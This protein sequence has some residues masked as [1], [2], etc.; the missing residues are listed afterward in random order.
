[1]TE[2]NA[3]PLLVHAA[4]R[5]LLD[6]VNALLRS[7]GISIHSTWIPSLEDMPDALEQLNPEMLLTVDPSLDALADLATLRDQVAPSVPLVVLRELCTQ[8]SITADMLRGARDSVS[9]QFPDR[10]VAVIRRELRA[11][12][13]ERT[14]TNTLNVAQEYRRRLQV[15]VRSSRDAIAQVQEGIIVDVNEAW[16]EMLGHD[17]TEVLTGQ[18]VMDNFDAE[19]QEA[20]RGALAACARGRWNELPL[21]VGAILKNGQ[22]VALNLILSRSEHDGEPSVQLMS[23]ARRRDERQMAKELEAAVHQDPATGLW[24]RRRLLQLFSEQVQRPV[25]GGGR[26]LLCLRI[27]RVADIEREIGIMHTDELLAQFAGL[28]R[29]HAGPNDI[30][31]HL[32]GVTLAALVERGNMRDLEAWCTALIDKV[33]RHPFSAGGNAVQ[34]TCSIGLE[35]VQNGSADING[36]AMQAQE[37]LRRARERGGNQ[38]HFEQLEDQDTRK[39]A[40]DEVWVRHIK[41]ALAENRFRLVQHPVAS[42]AGDGQKIYDVGVRMIDL[43]GKDILPAEFMPAAARNQ[44][45][46]AID[47][48]VVEAALNAI[49]REKPHLLFVRLSGDSIQS[50]ELRD[51]LTARIKALK[52][53]PSRLCLQFAEADLIEQKARLVALIH[54]LRKLGVRIALGHVGINAESLKLLPDIKLDYIKIDGS[55]MQGLASNRDNQQLVRRITDTAAKGKI[56]TVAERVED[57]NTMAVVFQLGVQ[58]IQ[59]YLVNE[60]E[61][62]VLAS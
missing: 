27:D 1:V 60:P 58:Y 41:T 15:V 47:Q 32:G 35:Q 59:G 4:D 56:A 49:N 36:A 37:C 2:L 29:A 16:L 18:P 43:Q 34:A 55:L 20:L 40:Y 5:S 17:S 3:I 61:Q 39:H 8:E 11:F 14:L 28:L 22:S 52:A 33:S 51:W 50:G 12:R 23:P 26:Y 45:L 7:N 54:Q 10:A 48:W 57:A 30:I 24:T 62:V 9:A 53:D 38:L 13:M 42:L 21:K 46:P 19:S 44:L 25:P 6:Q 31:G